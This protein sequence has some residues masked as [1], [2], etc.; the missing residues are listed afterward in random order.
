MINKVIPE[1]DIAIIGAGPGGIST[2]LSLFC[3]DHTEYRVA[4]IDKS[5]FP[6]EKVCG[7]AVPSWIFTDLEEVSQGIH[8]RFLAEINPFLFRKTQLLVNRSKS[9][10]VEWSRPGYMVPRIILDN[11]L[12]K[13]T[14][15]IEG[16]D[17]MLGVDVAKIQR[18][19]NFFNLLDKDRNV[20]LKARY[21]IGSDGAP[22]TV[23][24]NLIPHFR[25]RIRSGSA[26]R[27]YYSNLMI[28][29]PEIARVCYSNKYSPGYFW[30]FPIGPN[31]ANVGFGMINRSR[32]KKN[33][34]L[35]DAF[36]Y[37]VNEFPEVRDLLA[38]GTRE[39]A[40]K[41]GFLPFSKG[42]GNLVGQ[43]FS[44][45]GDAANLNDPLSGDG[46]RNAVKSGILLGKNLSIQGDLKAYNSLILKS[47]HE[48]LIKKMQKE[49]KFRARLVRIGQFIPF[50][51]PIFAPLGQNR[52]VMKWIK[53]WI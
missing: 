22:S 44:L 48:A 31:R 10:T 29:D 27:T 19:D 2:A 23:V 39:E 30:L 18:R 43:G 1:Y 41:G 49:L 37:F 9:L 7:D 11:F 25:T 14:E 50:A 38:G 17:L 5:T 53:K 6:R 35:K 13:Q 34:N 42:V 45:V 12:L 40:L 46:I 15:D 28:K 8:D 32:R 3:G 36:E 51:L 20:F 47:Y 21:V 26:I 24:R 16:L 52:F 33:I 4:L